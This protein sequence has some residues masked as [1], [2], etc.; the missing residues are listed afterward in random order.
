[1]RLF[2]FRVFLAN[3]LKHPL[4]FTL[5]YFPDDELEEELEL[6]EW[7]YL[8]DTVD[9]VINFSSVPYNFM[10]NDFWRKII[11]RINPQ[12]PKR[13]SLPVQ[14]PSSWYTPSGWCGYFWGPQGNLH[15]VRAIAPSPVSSSILLA[16]HP[17][18]VVEILQLWKKGEAKYVAFLNNKLSWKLSIWRRKKRD[19]TVL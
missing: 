18:T 16:T 9:T 15:A 3:L 4:E 2:A 19:F 11:I 17:S 10:I 6:E 13:P 1:M 5:P 14:C 8:V 7:S 12:K